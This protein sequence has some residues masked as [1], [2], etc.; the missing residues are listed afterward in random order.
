MADLASGLSLQSIWIA[1]S[2]HEKSVVLYQ[3][4]KQWHRLLS[5]YCDEWLIGNTVTSYQA[6]Y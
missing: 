2:C 5:T 6:C 1:V 4:L 3:L